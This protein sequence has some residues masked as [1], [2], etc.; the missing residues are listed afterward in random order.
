LIFD[1]AGN[2][3]GTTS[4]GGVQGQG[5]VFKLTPNGS[6]WTES[7]LHPFGFPSKDGRQPFTNL[8]SDSAGNLYGTTNFGGSHNH[9]GGTVFMV[10]PT[11]TESV[12]YSFCSLAK[13]ADGSNPLAGVVFDKSGNLYGTT[14]FGAGGSGAVFKLSPKAGGGWKETV[15]HTFVGNDGSQPIAGLTFDAT[16]N[17]YGT[18]LGGGANG[19]GVV[20]EMIR[21]SSGHWT[22]KT[23]HNFAG[24]QGGANPAGAL[25]IDQEG[26]LYGTTTA[27][28]TDNFGVTFKLARN[29]SGGW[30]ETTLVTFTNHPGGNPSAELTF[31]T[32]GNLFGTT[33]GTSGT[34]GSVFESTP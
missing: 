12:L 27:G 29:S 18:T 26:N 1:R 13:C 31:G 5:T 14:Q 7:V 32:T 15:L 6:G 23:I 17:L 4:Y 2:L 25:I 19:V 30:H 34:A 16:G 20:F 24:K 11:G 10:T 3:Y 21:H 8:V 9:R 33:A 22:E 28:G